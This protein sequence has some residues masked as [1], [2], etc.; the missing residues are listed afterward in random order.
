MTPSLLPKL[1]MSNYGFY[2][3]SENAKQEHLLHPHDF[4]SL[5]LV[6]EDENSELGDIAYDHSVPKIAN[7]ASSSQ[8][9]SSSNMKD[10]P[11]SNNMHASSTESGNGNLPNNES[12][13]KH[14]DDTAEHDGDNES[15]LSDS[16]FYQEDSDE[17]DSASVNSMNSSHHAGIM[18]NMILIS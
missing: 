8:E 7:E 13:S 15:I 6:K 4:E 9:A 2:P 16:S 18:A 12:G 17:F 3:H 1:D 5:S 11:S 10:L 14:L